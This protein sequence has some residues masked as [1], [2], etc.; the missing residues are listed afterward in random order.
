MA[1]LCSSARFQRGPEQHAQR[2]GLLL[3]APLVLV[4]DAQEEDPGQFGHVLHRAGAVA[5]AHDVADAL[6][7]LIHRLLGGEA[8]AIAVLLRSTCHVKSLR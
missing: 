1:A 8:L 4:E 7:R 6:D 5:A 2:R 3:L